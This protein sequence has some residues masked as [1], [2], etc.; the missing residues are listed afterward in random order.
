MTTN[1]STIGCA[2]FKNV[3]HV[4][5]IEKQRFWTIFLSALRPPLLKNTTFIFIVS[6]PFLN[7]QGRANHEVQTVN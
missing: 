1:F 4:V 6:S 5:S 3:G 7:D 2:L